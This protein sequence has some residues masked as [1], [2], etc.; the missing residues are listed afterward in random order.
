MNKAI[1]PALLFT[2]TL[3]LH[4][5]LTS[6]ALTQQIRSFN[7]PLSSSKDL[8]P[9]DSKEETPSAPVQ[10]ERDPVEVGKKGQMGIHWDQASFDGASY[11]PDELQ[12]MITSKGFDGLAQHSYAEAGGDFDVDI[13]KSG[14][15]MAFAT[16]RY[17]TN[18]EIVLQSVKGKTVTLL[19]NDPASDMMPRFHPLQDQIAW[20]SNRYGNWDILM[21]PIDGGPQARP[22]QVT[23]SS[24]DEI[25]PTWSPD[26]KLLAYS[27]FNAMDGLWKIW[28]W[29]A[30]TRT[31]SD[32][33]EGL[34][35]EFKPVTDSKQ[36]RYTLVYQKHRRRDIPWYSV[37]T[38]SI[39]MGSDGAVEQISSPSEVV[40]DDKWAAINPCWS[41]DGTYIAFASV[42][43]SP[44]TQMQ[45]RIYRADDIWVVQESG[46]DL[47]QITSHNSPDWGPTWA[48]DGDHK[49]GRLFFNSLRNGH[50]NIWSMNPIIPGMLSAELPEKK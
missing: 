41:P 25:H 37:W 39:E 28:T 12:Q 9:K 11:R 24:D 47:T 43:K 45:A 36:G 15:R 27:R 22:M 17:N 44:I 40:S 50:E 16:T 5:C 7:R 34:F 30:T 35:P 2:A 13:D 42:R 18:P 6:A 10:P 19:T 29:D 46:I 4:G 48:T 14:K 8:K 49:S 3:L 31:L 20:S 32:I 26:G 21:K 38:I 33:T 1:L 23:S